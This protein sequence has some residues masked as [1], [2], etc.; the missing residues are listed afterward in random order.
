M[1]GSGIGQVLLGQQPDQ[2][3]L[4]Q[5]G[6]RWRHDADAD[7]YATPALA[8][9]V[10]TW[11]FRVKNVAAAL[12]PTAAGTITVRSAYGGEALNR[13]FQFL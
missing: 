1:A 3:L 7:R 4:E 9:G 8:L 11:E 13:P 10:C 12:R 6:H 5:A 2:R